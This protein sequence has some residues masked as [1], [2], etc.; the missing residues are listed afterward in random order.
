[1]L[2]TLGSIRQPQPSSVMKKYGKTIDQLETSTGLPKRILR[3]VID[4]DITPVDRNTS[5]HGPGVPRTFDSGEAFWVAVAAGLISH[6]TKSNLL[7]DLFDDLNMPVFYEFQD[8]LDKCYSAHLEI[9]D[10]LYFRLRTTRAGSTKSEVENKWHWIK[11]KGIPME[12]AS[13]TYEPRSLISTN[14][15]SY[16]IK[17][18]E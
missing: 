11:R 4:N 5:C 18:S 15:L 3:Y 10:G 6:G 2:P 1:M 14:L 12:E 13:T 8:E 16:V 9:G 17:S 7:K